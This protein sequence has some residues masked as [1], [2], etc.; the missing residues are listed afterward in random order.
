MVRKVF[1][2]VA[3]SYDVMNDAM[4]LGI[5]RCWKDQFVDQIGPLKTRKITNEKGE[6]VNEERLKI[7]DV[8]GGTGDISFRILNKAKKDSP[9][10]KIFIVYL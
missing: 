2:N 4:S 10:S 8:A 9:G 7:L 1:S 6:T 3:E 5:H